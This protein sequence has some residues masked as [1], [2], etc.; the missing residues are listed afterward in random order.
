MY[1]F[2]PHLEPWLYQ[3]MMQVAAGET[4]LDPELQLK[5]AVNNFPEESPA[6]IKMSSTSTESTQVSLKTKSNQT[7]LVFVNP[8]TG[9]ITGS[10]IREKMLMQIMRDLHGELLMGSF[11]SAF[12][13]LTA[14]WII[15]LIFTGLY[16]WWP[17]KKFQ[18]WGV[19]LPRLRSS[20]RLFWRD[21]HALTGV[22][23]SLI[24]LTLLL[25]GLPWT[26]L[27]G[28]GFHQVQALAGQSRP[29][30]AGRRARFKSEK[31]PEG[32]T[33]IGLNQAIAIAHQQGFSGSYSIRL[34]KGPQ[35]VYGFTKSRPVLEEALYVYI[36]QYTGKIINKTTWED[37]PA[38]AKVV[39]IGVRLHQGEWLGT[40]NLVLM[41]IGTVAVVWICFSGGI[42][43]WKRCS[44]GRFQ[45]PVLPDNWT[46]PRFIKVVIFGLSIISPLVG[47]S[48]IVVYLLGKRKA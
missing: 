42:M 19:F 47:I 11:G 37:Y 22:Y 21:L 31:P 10:L 14:C 3:D 7:R 38:L 9:E 26:V 20:P 34:P 40:P 1:L 36:D 48:L 32:A 25:T 17:H 6:G 2:K 30:A 41:L 44:R 16:L 39:S 35:G 8:Y 28:A 5:A 43:W 4:K 23:T 18:I 29:E 27:W 46:P 33:S 15:I 45:A 12:V 13:E 24:I